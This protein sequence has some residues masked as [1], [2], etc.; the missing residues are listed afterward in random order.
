MELLTHWLLDLAVVE[1]VPLRLILPEVRTDL[2][3]VRKISQITPRDYADCLVQLARDGQLC[4]KSIFGHET[5]QEAA[6][7][8]AR[9]VKEP[10]MEWN[11]WLTEAGGRRWEDFASPQ[12]NRFLKF[13]QTTDPVFQ[14]NRSLNG[15]LASQNRDLLIAFSG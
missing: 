8:L 10:T 15:V 5:C 9:A 14:E 12:W 2:L 6:N 11:I 3:N 7:V 4:L 1:P 13:E